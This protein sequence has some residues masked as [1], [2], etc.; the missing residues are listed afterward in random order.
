MQKGERY[1]INRPY[2]EPPNVYWDL[3]IGLHLCLRLHL[4]PHIRNKLIKTDEVVTDHISIY[5]CVA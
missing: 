4:Q 3:K 1:L 2:T 5:A